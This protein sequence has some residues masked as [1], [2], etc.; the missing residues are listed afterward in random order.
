MFIEYWLNTMNNH[1]GI[2]SN[3]E[4]RYLDKTRKESRKFNLERKNITMNSY[5]VSLAVEALI[6]NNFNLYWKNNLIVGNLRGWAKKRTEAIWKNEIFNCA[7]IEDLFYYNFK[8]EFDWVKSLDFINNNYYY[9]KFQCNDADTKER[10]YKIKILLK[11]LPIYSLLQS[12]LDIPIFDIP[13]YY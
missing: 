5:E 12:N 7:K 1:I 10:S 11:D 4:L 8:N 6:V 3:S 2:C 13:I 9:S